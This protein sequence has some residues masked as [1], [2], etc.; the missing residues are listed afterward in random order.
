M[1]NRTSPR[2]GQAP[3]TGKAGNTIEAVPAEAEADATEWTSSKITKNQMAAK[4][5]QLEKKV[6]EMQAKLDAQANKKRTR[7]AL[8]QDGDEEAEGSATDIEEN[9][10]GEQESTKAKKVPKAKKSA[11]A[12]AGGRTSRIAAT[13]KEKATAGAPAMDASLF[14]EFQQFM[15]WKAKSQQHATSSQPMEQEEDAKAILRYKAG[16]ICFLFNFY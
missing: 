12:S 8:A 14:E 2:K 6:K 15:A 13:V 5:Q 7:S 1:S 10:E 9:E 16:Q 4:G 3:S 11:M